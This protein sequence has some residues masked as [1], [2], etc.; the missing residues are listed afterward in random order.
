[1]KLIRKNSKI[2]INKEEIMKGTK[3][4]NC[5]ITPDFYAKIEQYKKYHNISLEKLIH[6][7]LDEFF[8]IGSLLEG[9]RKRKQIL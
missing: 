5:F 9:E 4:I 3:E 7:A 1:M 2:Y 8:D 6:T